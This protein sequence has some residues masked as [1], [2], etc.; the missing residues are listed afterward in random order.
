MKALLGTVNQEQD[1]LGAFFSVI[2]KLLSSRRFVPSFIN[3]AVMKIGPS[4]K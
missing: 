4:N 2:V 3:E 1:L